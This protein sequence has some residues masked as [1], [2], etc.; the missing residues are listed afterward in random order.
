MLG[1]ILGI[2]YCLLNMLSNISGALIKLLSVE[3][4]EHINT[5]QLKRLVL[6]ALFYQM[7]NQNAKVEQFISKL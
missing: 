1:S 5:N 2:G 7:T 4:V 3:Y 6:L